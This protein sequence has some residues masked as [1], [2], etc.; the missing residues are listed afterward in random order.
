ML[1]PLAGQVSDLGKSVNGPDYHPTTQTNM[2]LANLS[3]Q[4]KGNSTDIR[5]ARA[6]RVTQQIKLHQKELVQ[7]IELKILEVESKLDELLDTGPTHTTS[8]KVVPDGFQPKQFV[9]KI[10][11]LRL[12]LAML[13]VE[14]K[15]A[16]ETQAAIFNES[17]TTAE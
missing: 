3:T 10:H 11:E 6:D 16:T 5:N 8:L 14:L 12:E 4:L 7:E 13:N 9:R 17:P 2:K 15:I 1:S